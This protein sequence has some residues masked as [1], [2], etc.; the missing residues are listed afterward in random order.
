MLFYYHKVWIALHNCTNILSLVF[1]D[2]V[3][4]LVWIKDCRDCY[5]SDSVIDT[6]TE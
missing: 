4:K 5:F 6:G 2:I 3:V 1:I